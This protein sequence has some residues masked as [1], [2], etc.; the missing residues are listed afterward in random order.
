MYPGMRRMMWMRMAREMSGHRRPHHHHHDHD[1]SDY[2]W[3]RPSAEQ[4]IAFLE[5]YQRDLEEQVADVAAKIKRLRDEMAG[6]TQR[7]P[8]AEG[9]EG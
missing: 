1:C 5:E 2:G 7:G 3:E 8:E 6:S 4:R 9:G